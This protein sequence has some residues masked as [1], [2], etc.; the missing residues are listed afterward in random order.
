MPMELNTIR[1]LVRDYI[2]KVEGL[3]YSV[4]DSLRSQ[5]DE[6]IYIITFIPLLSPASNGT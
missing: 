6:R 3:T 5:R 2:D 4:Y 1:Q